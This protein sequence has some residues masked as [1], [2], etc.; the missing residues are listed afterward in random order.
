[1]HV[2]IHQHTHNTFAISNALSIVMYDV[3]YD[4]IYDVIS[5]ETSCYMDKCSG[6]A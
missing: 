3:M 4:V 1:M 2:C 6:V 5:N